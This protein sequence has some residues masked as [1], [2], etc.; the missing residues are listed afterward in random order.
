MKVLVT[1]SAGQVAQVFLAAA[2][3]SSLTFRCLDI[4]ATPGQ[5]E[6]IVGDISDLDTVVAAASGCDAIVH[7]THGGGNGAPWEQ[8]LKAIAPNLPPNAWHCSAAPTPKAL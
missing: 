5:P 6:S 1:G 4:V 7:L 8:A 2:K 3:N